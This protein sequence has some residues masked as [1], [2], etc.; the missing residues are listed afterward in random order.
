MHGQCKRI[1]LNFM[2]HGIVL[3]MPVMSLLWMTVVLLQ[4]DIRAKGKESVSKAN[5]HSV[6]LPDTGCAIRKDA[7]VV[8][9]QH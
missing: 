4:A 9:V 8:A 1:K 3:Y 5:L 7:D 2:V 6:G